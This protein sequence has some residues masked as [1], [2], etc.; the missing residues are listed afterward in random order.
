MFTS[1]NK[2]RCWRNLLLSARVG[3]LLRRFSDGWFGGC[4][5]IQPVSIFPLLGKIGRN[6]S[7]EQFSPDLS[8]L[9]SPRPQANE[10]FAVHLTLPFPTLITTRR[11][12]ECHD[13]RFMK[14]D[15]C[16]TKLT[17]ACVL[18]GFYP[19]PLLSWK[20]IRIVALEAF[21]SLAWRRSTFV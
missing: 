10:E 2:W 20:S 13:T 4:A 21:L 15:A 19:L 8:T 6:V 12:T 11:R 7:L 18:L 1:K 14:L 9:S 16:V 17:E 5:S 3:I